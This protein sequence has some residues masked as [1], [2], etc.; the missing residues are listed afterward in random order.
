MIVMGGPHTVTVILLIIQAATL[1]AV[2]GL[3]ALVLAQRRRPSGRRDTSASAGMAKA[4]SAAARRQASNG[5]KIRIRAGGCVYCGAAATTLDH[6]RPVSRGGNN[7]ES[8]LVGCCAMCNS[9]KCDKLITEWMPA[10]VLHAV[11]AEPKVYA[12]LVRLRNEAARFSLRALEAG[13]ARAEADGLEAIGAG[14]LIGLTEA[15]RIG[16]LP[17]PAGSTAAR[18]LE[19][20]RKARQ[21]DPHFPQ[22][23]QGGPAGIEHLYDAHELAT[24][25]RN[26]PRAGAA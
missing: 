26:R 4:P 22:A 20:V 9:A 8:N 3:G 6:I 15:I 19:A 5:I 2:L 25:T 23:R 14:R 24:W 17:V 7:D 11:A 12:E 18:W 13:Q 16:V 10:R 1:A 21:Y